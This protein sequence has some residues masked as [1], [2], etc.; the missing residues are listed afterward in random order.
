MK[1]RKR[2][3]TALRILEGN[4]EKRPLPDAEPEL[5]Y[6]SGPPPAGLDA[7]ARAEWKRIGDILTTAR[8]L[9]AGDRAVLVVYCAE[10]SRFLKAERIIGKLGEMLVS[11]AGGLYQNP[12]LAVSR[13]AQEHILKCA[14]VLGLDPANRSKVIAGKPVKA[15]FEAKPKDP[16]AV[17]G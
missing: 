15:G 12:W 1:G 6:G 7:A 2:K 16:F 14:A 5:P 8:V 4:R 17:T 9:T 3:P 13:R 10:W 11:E